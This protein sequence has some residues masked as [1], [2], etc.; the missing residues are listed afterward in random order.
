MSNVNFLSVSATTLP[1]IVIAIVVEARLLFNNPKKIYGRFLVSWMT[2]IFTVPL[3]TIFWS[4]D[5]IFRTL[6]GETEPSYLKPLVL[7]SVSQGML[8]LTINPILEFIFRGFA[9]TWA[10]LIVILQMPL[11]SGPFQKSRKNS[12]KREEMLKEVN[13]YKV[14]NDERLKKSK[15]ILKMIDEGEL[16]INLETR[17]LTFVKTG[18]A[19]GMDL[20]ELNEF[21]D[22]AEN[23][24]A[25]IIEVLETLNKIQVPQGF[26]EIWGQRRKDINELEQMIANFPNK[27]GE[28]PSRD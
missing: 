13:S 26:R 15:V 24:D 18:E 19:S 6:S 10:S 27:Y 28:L 23:V 4:E 17:E 25:K 11:S 7:F 16:R 5:R 20:N 9:R 14:I 3:G 22:S 2:I 12:K 1:I 8:A 21:I